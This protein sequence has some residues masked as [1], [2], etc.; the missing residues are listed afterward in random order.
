METYLGYLLETSSVMK[1]GDIRARVQTMVVALPANNSRKS[2]SKNY[3]PSPS[4]HDN[5]AI[6]IAKECPFREVLNTNY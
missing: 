5:E 4:V 3:T 6:N 1:E 2:T